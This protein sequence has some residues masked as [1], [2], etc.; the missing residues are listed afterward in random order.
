[1]TLK[2]VG[3]A[4]FYYPLSLVVSCRGATRVLD[5]VETIIEAGDMKTFTFEGI[6]ATKECL[7]KVSLTLTSP[8]AMEG[9]SIKFAQGY[10]G[11]VSLS[12]PSPRGNSNSGSVFGL[13]MIRI[14]D[15]DSWSIVQ[16]LHDDDVVDLSKVGK[17]LSVRADIDGTIASVSFF[18]NGFLWEN[19]KKAPFALGGSRGDLFNIVS[20]L[21]EPGTKTITAIAH[22]AENIVVGNR[23]VTF[24]VLEIVNDPD[25]MYH[26]VLPDFS[27][28]STIPRVTPVD[29]PTTTPTASPSTQL[30]KLLAL[31]AMG[32]GSSPAHTSCCS[33]SAIGHS[34]EHR[35]EERTK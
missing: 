33:G 31:S 25:T 11:E 20:I 8:F 32:D 9:R 27:P 15:D 6:P 2:Q 10:D 21:G 7:D 19:Q 35:N 17:H 13:S 18:Y 3:V 28:V 12:L 22:N 16:A 5:S 1:V 14:Y 24:S 34:D 23:T 29:I 26:P 4:P 30:E